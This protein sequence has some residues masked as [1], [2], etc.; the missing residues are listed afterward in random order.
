MDVDD[1]SAASLPALEVCPPLH[2]EETLQLRV[3]LLELP[4]NQGCWWQHSEERSTQ[5]GLTSSA[6]HT[7]LLLRGK[8]E[9]FQSF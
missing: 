4:A 3:Q 6:I 8:S 2:E 9:E 7:N 5:I 1:G